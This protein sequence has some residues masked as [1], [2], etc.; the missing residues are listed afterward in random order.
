[1]RGEGGRERGGGEREGECQYS[2]PPYGRKTIRGTCAKECL[3]AS[4]HHFH[5]YFHHQYHLLLHHY[6]FYHYQQHHYHQHCQQRH[7]HHCHHHRQQHYHDYQRAIDQIKSFLSW[8]V[9]V[10]D[11]MPR[12]W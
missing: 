10:D 11:E 1:M 4:H 7:C 5:H 8:C 9:V 2:P 3:E 6:Y 12:V